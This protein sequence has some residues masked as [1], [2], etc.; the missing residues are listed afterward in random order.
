MTSS[1]PDAPNVDSV[2]PQRGWL[3]LRRRS[4]RV[5]FVFGLLSMTFS[6]SVFVYKFKFESPD[7]KEVAVASAL[8]AVTSP[9][10]APA[11]PVVPK[12]VSLPAPEVT[13]PPEE[14]ARPPEPPV[15]KPA[16]VVPPAPEEETRP[17]EKKKEGKKTAALKKASPSK[18]KKKSVAPVEQ[19]PPA[20]E[21]YAP[22][23]A[24][25]PWQGV[26][27]KDAQI[28][29]HFENTDGEP[30]ARLV[31]D[32]QE[33]A[34]AQIVQSVDSDFSGYELLRFSFRG[35]GEAA[36]NVELRLEDEDGTVAGIVF[37][38]KA[39]IADWVNVKIPLKTLK[40]M[41][42]GGD[43]TMDWSRVRSIG[44]VVSGKQWTKGSV[45][46]KAIKFQ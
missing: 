6:A 45:W 2:L 35:D 44:M 25:K 23:S 28:L 20:P 40:V 32:L 13:L 12:P 34:W 29:V 5:W 33:G 18:K 24:S 4:D 11:V 3:R 37:K 14:P 43:G 17:K 27:D 7:T 22:L 36:N 46:Y 42:P 38:G 1:D 30:A 15:V 41:H 39:G 8:S 21:P 31:Y 26:F 10:I 16:A 19:T 9:A